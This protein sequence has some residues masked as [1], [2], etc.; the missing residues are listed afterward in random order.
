MS[1][2]NDGGN[3][4]D[5][6]R[7][8]C[9]V[10][11]VEHDLGPSAAHPLEAPF[12][13][14]AFG[15]KGPGGPSLAV[16]HP[17]PATSTSAP[18]CP[19]STAADA[20]VGSTMSETSSRRRRRRP[21]HVQD[22]SPPTSTSARACLGLPPVDLDVGLSTSETSSRRPRRRPDHIPDPSRPSPARLEAA[23]LVL[24]IDVLRLEAVAHQYRLATALFVDAFAAEERAKTT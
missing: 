19:G 11:V 10:G 6:E 7:G 14:R 4:E 15:P 23:A 2:T 9:S 1:G 13:M 8:S 16:L 3:D 12:V 21:E 18:A 20:D 22:L 24:G 17:D 5:A